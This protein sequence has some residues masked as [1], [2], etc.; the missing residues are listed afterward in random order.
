MH[1]SAVWLADSKQPRRVTWDE[2]LFQ[3]FG[4]L[5]PG[6]RLAGLETLVLMIVCSAVRCQIVKDALKSQVWCIYRLPFCALLNELEISARWSLWLR[7]V[8]FGFVSG[9]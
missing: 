4:K 7:Y 3:L 2:I 1:W 9:L 5:H 8:V 6:T